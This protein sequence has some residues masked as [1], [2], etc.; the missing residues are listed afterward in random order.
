MIT[1]TKLPSTRSPSLKVTSP[2]NSATRWRY[3]LTH[4]FVGTFNI[5]TITLY[6]KDF[7]VVW[8]RNVPHRPMYL[9]TWPSVGGTVWGGYLG[10]GALLEEL[11][12]EGDDLRF[13]APP[14]S[15]VQ[16]NCD[17]PPS[18]PCYQ[19]MH[20]QPWLL[21]SLY[22]KLKYSFSSCFWSS[23]LA[24][25]HKR[26]WHRWPLFPVPNLCTS[27]SL[28]TLSEAFTFHI[29]TNILITTVPVISRKSQAFSTLLICTSTLEWPLVG[30][31]DSWATKGGCW[32]CR[33]PGFNSSTHPG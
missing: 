4:G 18:H 15:H 11:C 2:A 33:G 19:V 9:S 26:N 3:P 16:M 27:L 24:Q 8:M 12:N 7:V 13:I 32:T 29:S 30:W 31:R 5:K 25:Q 1:D 6:D 14:P 20:S 17:Q 10:G 23:I 28:E 22:C 21:L